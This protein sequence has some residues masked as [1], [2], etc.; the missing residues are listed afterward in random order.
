VLTSAKV[1]A[2]RLPLREAFGNNFSVNILTVNQA[3]SPVYTGRRT[4]ALAW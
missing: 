4:T 1:E 3:R 2:R